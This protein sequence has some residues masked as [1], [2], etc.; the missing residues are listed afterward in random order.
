MLH[1][2][3]SDIMV[4]NYFMDIVVKHDAYH[5]VILDKHESYNVFF[6]FW[7]ISH[8][9]KYLNMIFFSGYIL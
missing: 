4:R 3:T 6:K 5:M 7:I 1:L 9:L 8:F 2:F